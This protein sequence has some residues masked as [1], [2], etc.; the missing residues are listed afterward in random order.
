VARD[1][2]GGLEGV[3]KG[4]PR[5]V[6]ILRTMIPTPSFFEARAIKL[7]PLRWWFVALST[8]GFVAL[9]L[10]PVVLSSPRAVLWM[11]RLLLPPIIWVWGLLLVATW[12]H[13]QRGTLRLG[14]PWLFASRGLYARTTRAYAALFLAALF[15]FAIVLV[16]LF[17]GK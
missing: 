15:P 4:R 13:P 11:T 3:E 14:S 12:F 5:S 17:R 1:A 7:F 9:A 8:V 10:T 2:A 16:A 6:T